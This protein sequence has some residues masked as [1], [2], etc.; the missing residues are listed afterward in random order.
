MD[1]NNGIIDKN[2]YKN[3]SKDSNKNIDE[4]GVVDFCSSTFSH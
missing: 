3:I 4:F 2:I 1:N